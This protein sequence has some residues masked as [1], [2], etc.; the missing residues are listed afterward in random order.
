MKKK[1]LKEDWETVF[2]SQRLILKPGSDSYQ[3]P[4]SLKE[5]IL[6]LQVEPGN[7]KGDDFYISSLHWH[8]ET[9]DSTKPQISV[10]FYT[11][12]H[13][14]DFWDRFNYQELIDNSYN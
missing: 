4:F 12:K 2:K 7:S 9:I 11:K 13:P 3:V 8:S 5:A 10:P 1:R 6:N 14:P